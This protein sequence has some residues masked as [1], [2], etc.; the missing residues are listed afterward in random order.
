MELNSL[1]KQNLSEFIEH[2]TACHSLAALESIARGPLRRL[3]PHGSLVAAIGH[4]SFGMIQVDHLLGVDAPAGFV[5]Y[6]QAGTPMIERKFM[7]QWYTTRAPQC[8]DITVNPECLSPLEYDEVIRYD[9]R[10]LAI[11]GLIDIDGRA[12]SYF[13]FSRLPSPPGAAELSILERVTPHLHLAFTQSVGLSTPAWHPN[14]PLSHREQCI[15][16]LLMQG[17]SNQQMADSIGSSVHTVRT[18]MYRLFGKLKVHSRTDAI[19]KARELG[20]DKLGT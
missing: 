13:S 2:S 8:M 6:L 5:E 17:L 1:N 9:L 7:V 19:A 16:H 14:A 15:L 11:H 20:L 3:L 18:Q 10:N 4:L 12:A